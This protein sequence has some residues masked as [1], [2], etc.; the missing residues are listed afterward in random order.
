[1]RAGIL[2]WTV[3]HFSNLG[4]TRIAIYTQMVFVII[5]AVGGLPGFEWLAYP[6]TAYFLGW[7]RGCAT[8]PSSH[9]CSDGYPWP[10]SGSADPAV[11][12][13]FSAC[14][15]LLSSSAFSISGP[16]DM[17]SLRLCC[18]DG[19]LYF[20]SIN[21]AVTNCAD[22]AEQATVMGAV[23][24]IQVRNAHFQSSVALAGF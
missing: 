10:Q 8:Q 6:A 16:L 12:F 4:T 5:I 22:K 14:C 19:T 2:P 17:T 11:D 20:P 23:H 13:P 9:L 3:K 18:A 1:M 7:W 15:R 24:G 21:A